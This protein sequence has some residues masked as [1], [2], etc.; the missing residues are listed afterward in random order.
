MLTL[1]HRFG[2]VTQFSL[3]K[4]DREKL[5]NM[6]IKP[7]LTP[8]YPNMIIHKLVSTLQELPQ[9]CHY[10]TYLSLYDNQ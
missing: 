10:E 8:A 9:P 3:H 5:E 7:K 2:N 1:H 6:K 4:Y